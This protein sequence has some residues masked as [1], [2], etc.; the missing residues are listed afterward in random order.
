MARRGDAR[1]RSSPFTTRQVCRQYA[2]EAKAA[3]YRKAVAAR[4]VE[5]FAQSDRAFAVTS[6][7]WDRDPFMLGTPGGTVDLR[8]A[9]MRPA[10]QTDFI[11]RL[12]AIAPAETPECPLWLDFLDKAAGGDT[13]LIR[14]LRQWCGYSLTGDIR[15]HALLFIHGQ[16]GN[17]KGVFLGTLNGILGD[18]CTMAA[19]DT[20][21]AAAGDRHPTD[22]ARLKGARMVTASETEEGRAWAEV[23]INQLTGGD[24]IAARF[25][26]QDF[27]EFTPQF[28]LTVIGN[29]RP[30]LRNINDAARRRFNIVPFNH[31][32]QT[33]DNALQAKLQQEWPAILR[34][35]LEGCIDWQMN[36]LIRPFVVTQATAD[37]FREQDTFRQWVGDRCEEGPTHADTFANLFASW[38]NY[39]LQQGEEPGTSKSFSAALRRADYQPI[40]DESGIRGRGFRGLKATF[41]IDP[42]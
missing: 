34:W 42:L 6:E 37:Y 1:R 3:G 9:E 27:F 20:F 2:V 21:T 31:K 13:G 29:H 7:V 24:K 40:R 23:R 4:A 26:R 14:F 38:R 32:P 41:A 30:A 17:G 11:T 12:T 33:P 16:G 36:G 39:A 35:M 10:N 19:M 8:T 28:K 25:M 5:Q 22:L 18:Y 15:E